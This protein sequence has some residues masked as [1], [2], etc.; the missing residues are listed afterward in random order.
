MRTC[1]K[2]ELCRLNPSSVCSW[3]VWAPW[4]TFSM[5][6]QPLP[7][8]ESPILNGSST[9]SLN[10]AG[11]RCLRPKEV[12]DATPAAKP[13]CSRSST[14][15][16]FASSKQWRKNPFASKT[17]SE[18]NALRRTIKEQHYDAVVDLQG[19]LR[20]AVIGRM[21][22]SRR[23]IGESSPREWAARWLF[24]ERID[25]HARACD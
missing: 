8:C 21:A 4:A 6:C 5:P 18:I 15:L 10:P 13:R 24:T 14:R 9:G 16:H 3:S 22:G 2:I 23:F 25:T 17:C 7:R 20:S 19:A 11:V 1:E 12:P